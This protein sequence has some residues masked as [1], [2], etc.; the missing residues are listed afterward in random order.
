M[1]S[2]V[3]AGDREG[4]EESKENNKEIRNKKP[5]TLI[6]KILQHQL[7]DYAGIPRNPPGANRNRKFCIVKNRWS[8][9]FYLLTIIGSGNRLFSAFFFFFFSAFNSITACSLCSLYILS[10][11]LMM[12][13]LD[14]WNPFL[15]LLV[16]F[17]VIAQVPGDNV[18]QPVNCVGLPLCFQLPFSLSPDLF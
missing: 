7:D 17:P 6:Y 13:F 18:F 15:Y 9:C 5:L 10:E 8:F 16:N 12:A 14:L 2:G 3:L 4:Q 11:K 1:E